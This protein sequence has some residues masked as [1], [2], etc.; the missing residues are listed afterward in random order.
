MKSILPKCEKCGSRPFSMTSDGLPA[1]VGFELEDG[2][3]I[4]LCKHCL[5][6]LGRAKESGNMEEWD[7]FLEQF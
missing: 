6:D 2:T 5:M 4:N 3:V 1:M 7:K